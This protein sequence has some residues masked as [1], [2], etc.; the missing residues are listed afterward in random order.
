MGETLF[1]FLGV[2]VLLLGVLFFS[3]PARN[4]PPSPT[5]SPAKK[6]NKLAVPLSQA[7]NK[8]RQSLTKN[9]QCI[10]KR[11][12]NITI[13]IDAILR[14]SLGNQTEYEVASER[15]M[16][17]LRHLCEFAH[18]FVIIDA[19]SEED[20]KRVKERLKELVMLETSSSSYPILDHRLLFHTTSIGKKAI[21]RQILP[22]VHIDR[23]SE[24][25]EAISPFISSTIQVD[26][27]SQPK[28]WRTINSF[29]CLLVD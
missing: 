4:H 23:D 19:K 26:T 18:I 28:A 24:I 12:L 29:D 21:V 10:G 1:W 17:T 9:S 5:Q 7:A 3:T 27:A 15:A 20:E 16:T 6:D 8:M 25:C 2:A 22:D 11:V 13:S 14:K